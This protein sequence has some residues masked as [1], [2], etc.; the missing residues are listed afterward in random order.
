M[1]Q[2]EWD[3]KV[4]LSELGDGL[5][6]RRATRMDA[7]KLA[8][9]NAR[10]HSDHGP[11][12][13]VG[14]W[15]RD[16]AEKPH[17]TFDVGDFT[18]VEDSHSGKIVSSLNL[19]SQ[20]WA[21]G[22]IPFGVGRP[23]LVGT[24]PEFRGR[25]LVRIQFDVIHRW[26]A[27]RGHL[28]QGITGIPYY[29]RQFGYEMGVDLD[30]GRTGLKSNAPKLRE[31]EAEFFHIRPAGDVDVPFIQECYENGSRRSLVSCV[32][33][34]DLWRYELFGKSPQSITRFEIRVI[35]TAQAGSSDPRV[36]FLLHPGSNWG[37][38]FPA[39]LYE[40]KPGVSWGAVT[41]SVIR[42]LVA[43]GE[44]NAAARGQAGSLDTFGM[45][46]GREHPAYDVLHDSLN[47]A[48]RPYSWYIRVPD[49]PAFL[50]RVSPVLEQR[51]AN[52][53]YTAHSGE[54]K[55][56]F[57]R[58]GL[59]LLFER[60]RLTSVETWKPEPQGHSGH[61]G[62]PDLTFLQMLFGHR[63]LEELEYAFADCFH[64]SDEVFGLLSTLFPKLPS[65]I[66]PV[67]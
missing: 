57:Y 10:I 67:S 38:M 50:R 41:P 35:E 28:L 30:R 65:D 1:I 49:L 23:E 34:E 19:I 13:R 7:E 63:S 18:L 40:L 54:L 24:L 21:Y 45:W 66:M 46:L 64:R 52:S 2:A 33:N 22:G 6:L 56:S 20:T 58:S 48:R 5:L 39:N 3:E 12:E 47:V 44:A 11:D 37:S 61:A 51:L 60:G 62:Y 25:G 4:I 59:R 26:S 36:G 53:A 31:G 27:E 55:I 14:A 43:T 15:T 17:P 32:W 29:Y 8:Q 42:Y 16:L 9:F